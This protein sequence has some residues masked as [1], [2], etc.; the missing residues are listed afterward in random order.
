[1]KGIRKITTWY[2]KICLQSEDQGMKK[3]KYNGAIKLASP[4]VIRY[5]PYFSLFFQREVPRKVGG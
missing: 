3:E 4:K 2:C 1:M 5:V